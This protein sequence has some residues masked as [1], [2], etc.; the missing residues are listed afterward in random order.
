MDKVP[1]P[2]MNVPVVVFYGLCIRD[3]QISVLDEYPVEIS[4]PSVNCDHRL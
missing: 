1:L 4:V 2:F 3:G